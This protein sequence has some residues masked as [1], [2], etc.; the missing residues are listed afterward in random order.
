MSFTV[1]FHPLAEKE[2]TD[3]YYWYETK[4]EGLGERL[5]GK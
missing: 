1:Y 3:S 2:V 4:L 5:Q